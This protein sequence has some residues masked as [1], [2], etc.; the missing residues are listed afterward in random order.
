MRSKSKDRTI[1]Y[2]NEVGEAGVMEIAAAMHLNKGN[3]F[4]CLAELVDAG[5]VKKTGCYKGEIKYTLSCA[6][7]EKTENVS[8]T[9]IQRGQLDNHFL[10]CG[11]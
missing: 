6:T 8:V 1:A 10:S 3:V 9:T 4:K 11:C 7:G 5:I 2:L